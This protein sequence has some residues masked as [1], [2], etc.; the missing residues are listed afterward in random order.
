MVIAVDGPAGAGKST[1]CRLVAERLG[2]IYLDT[3]AMYRAVAWALR[4][5]GAPFEEDAHLVMGL[6]GLPLHFAIRE[7]ALSIIYKGREI[8]G[9]L[10]EPDITR[11]ASEVSQRP[12]VR[13]YLTAWQRKLATAGNI[14]AEGRDMTTVVFPDADVKV[15]I[16]AD[17]ATRTRRRQREYLQKGM[18]VD[19]SQLLKEIRSRDEADAGRGIAPLR[20]AE[21][22][23]FLDTSCLEIDQVVLRIL[24]LT[25]GLP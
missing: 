12:P 14:V 17:L 22:A 13:D 3:G 18:E 1:V 9:D 4:E 25:E 6:K 7:N 24:S 21:D 23:F 16:T 20:P 5:T 2:F 10:R 15:F 19:F 11:L 8:A